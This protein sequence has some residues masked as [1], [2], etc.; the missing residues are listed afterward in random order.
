MLD[1]AHIS[2]IEQM[3]DFNV[4]LTGFLAEHDQD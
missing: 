4:A 2:N 3:G 1:A